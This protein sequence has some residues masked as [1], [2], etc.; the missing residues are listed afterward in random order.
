V[1]PYRAI[2]KLFS[3][4]ALEKLREKIMANKLG[5]EA[6]HVYLIAGKAY[7]SLKESG[8]KQA[9]VISGESGAGKT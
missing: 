2:D 3:N 7:I 9:I 6:P 4:G 8:I 5:K 1:N